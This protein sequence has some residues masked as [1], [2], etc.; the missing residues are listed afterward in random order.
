MAQKQEKLN[1]TE[2]S[3]FIEILNGIDSIKQKHVLNSMLFDRK[4]ISQIP[5]ETLEH[6]ATS[7]NE[8]IRDLTLMNSLIVERLPKDFLVEFV[9]KLPVADRTSILKQESITKKFSDGELFK[10]VR[11][12]VE[13]SESEKDLYCAAP[14]ADNSDIMERLPLQT[15]A[16]LKIIKENYDA[17]NEE[18]HR[19]FDEADAVELGKIAEDEE[20]KEKKKIN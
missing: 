15:A 11:E 4:L 17:E 7:N 13:L 14:L 9:T 2:V 18:L 5:V 8:K 19:R 1:R 6:L 16:K 20:I 3:R 10:F 12:A